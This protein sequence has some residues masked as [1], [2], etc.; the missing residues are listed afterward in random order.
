[1]K[2]AFVDELEENN[3]LMFGSKGAGTR[4][5]ALVETAFTLG[6]ILG[7]VLSGTLI[8]AVGYRCMNVTFGEIYI[9]NTLW[10]S[11]DFL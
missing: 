8:A 1:M 9:F 10:Q 2:I 4:V 6:L 3:P 5:F 11:T 7:P